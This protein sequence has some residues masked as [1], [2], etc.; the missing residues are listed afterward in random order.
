MRY[1]VIKDMDLSDLIRY[2][3][4]KLSEGWT[5]VEGVKTANEGR[6]VYYL[7]TMVKRDEHC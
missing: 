2:V 6:T 4:I 5:L 3:N 7:Q 1:T